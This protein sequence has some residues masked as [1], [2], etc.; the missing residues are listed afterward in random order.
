MVDDSTTTLYVNNVSEKVNKN[1]LKRSIH[2]LFSRCGKVTHIRNGVG[3][4]GKGQIWV[5]FD[6]A[7]AAAAAMRELQGFDF[8]GKKLKIALAKKPSGS[9]S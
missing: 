2:M 1:T 5:R 8:S 6:N 9:S 4:A 3:R 7:E